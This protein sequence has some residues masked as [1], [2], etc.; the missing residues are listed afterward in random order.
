M[1]DG[2]KLTMTGDQIRTRLEDRIE[3]HRER[4][5]RWR[6]AT[7]E[8]D[9]TSEPVQLPVHMCEHEAERHQWRA[10]VLT[11]IRDHVETAETYRLTE[12][13]LEFA[14]LLPEKPWVVEQADYEERHEMDMQVRRLARSIEDLPLLYQDAGFKATRIDTPGG[15]EI[16]QIERTQADG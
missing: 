4:S 1:I 2:L 12:V 10:D 14:E 11:F 8:D 15:P 7:S 16:I 5:E 3:D 6:R 9:D 13:D